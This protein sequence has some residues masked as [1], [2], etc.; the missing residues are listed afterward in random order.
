MI[1]NRLLAAA[2]AATLMCAAPAF[3]QQGGAPKNPPTT[4]R[5]THVGRDICATHPNLPQ[6]S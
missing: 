5:A 3:A 6:C 4:H 1:A 2:I